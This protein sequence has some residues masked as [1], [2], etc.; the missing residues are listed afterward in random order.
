MINETFPDLLVI[1]ASLPGISGM[2]LLRQVRS[3]P[4][5][6]HHIGTIFLVRERD[7]DC[8]A[9]A[10]ELGIDDFCIR[11]HLEHELAPRVTSVNRI[12]TQIDSLNRANDKLRVANERLAK[13]TITDDLT[14][15][16][17]MRYFKRRLI[18]EFTRAQRY[19]KFLSIVMFDVDY[20]KRVNDLNDHLM[21]SFVLAELGKMVAKEIRTVD[22]AARFGGDEF[23]IMLPETG[24]GGAH[25]AAV[26]IA[27]NVKAR[28]FEHN[29]NRFQITLSMG[30]ATFGPGSETFENGTELLRRA[31]Q[32]LYQA[33]EGGRDQIVDLETS[34]KA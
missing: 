14:G 30:I 10:L 20:F 16:Y 27:S 12:R 17:N 8:I 11:E 19:D 13:I 34:Q 9:R 2:E 33:K 25:N 15:L 23:V 5:R 18:Q 7:T 1:D 31:D 26:R 21:G 32:Y 28:V 24:A 6:G 4:K 29:D 22:I 3:S